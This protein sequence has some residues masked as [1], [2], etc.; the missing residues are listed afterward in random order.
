MSDFEERLAA[1]MRYGAEQARPGADPMTVVA[2]RA[3][4][5][6][7]RGQL[8]VLAGLMVLLVI[9]VPSFLASRRDA[10][11]ARPA[12]VRETGGGTQ[13]GA[14]A[15]LLTTGLFHDH[16][17]AHPV[18]ALEVT[19]RPGGYAFLIVTTSPRYPEGKTYLQELT[20]GGWVRLGPHELDPHSRVSYLLRPPPGVLDATYRVYVPAADGQRE[21]YSSP[22]AVHVRP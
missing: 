8:A 22:V 14:P 19:V 15:W 5:R 7:H 2:D 1:S 20:A 16:A 18:P 10:A 17:G 3:D 12:A 6:R 4:R 13:A 11:P 9:A 21:A